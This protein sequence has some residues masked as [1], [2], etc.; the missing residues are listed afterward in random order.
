MKNTFSEKIYSLLL[1]IPPGKVVTYKDI[2]IKLNSKAY[3]AIG[4]ALSKNKHLVKVP[5]HRVIRSSGDI[6]G[7]VLGTKKKMKLLK[8]EGIE[9]INN[10][11]DLKKYSYKL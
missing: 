9:I 10:R 6:G 2:A 5:C 4:T 1:R 7:Y 8:K 3:Q 11:I